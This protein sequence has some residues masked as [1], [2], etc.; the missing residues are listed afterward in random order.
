MVKSADIVII[1]G[2]ISGVSIGY[3]LLKHGAK[4]VVI[5]EKNYLAAG[6]TGR[7]GA[8][9]RQQWGSPLNCIMSKF[10]CEFFES[11]A[12]EL[13][14][15]G[16]IEFHQ[17]G[18]M[19]LVSTEKEL[20]QT[21][22]NIA[23]QN[24]LGINTKLLTP[25]EAKDMAPLLDTNGILAAAFHGRDGHLNPF[26]TTRAFSHAFTRLGGKIYTSTG[27][28][29]IRVENGRITGVDT[30]RGHIA[31]N[32]VVN[33][34][35][36]YV[37]TIA[38]MIDVKLPLYSQRHNILVTE[39]VERVLDP[40][41]MSFSLNFYCQQTPHGSFIMGRTC[42][43]QP[44]DLRITA[45][46]RFPV[47]M[48]KTITKVLPRLK[49]LRMLRQWAGLYNMSPDS[50]PIYDRVPGVDGFY[51]AAGYSGHGFM[52]A[53]FT[54][55]AMTEIVLGLEPTLPWNKLGFSRFND[56]ELILE[57]SVV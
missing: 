34:A 39:P 52:L 24:S 2:G 55:M 56:G 44:R 22:E 26:T 14:Y 5:L 18:Y 51:L 20:A 4:N 41:L 40:M 43:D 54:G 35:G 19:M 36:G 29:G 17:G 21:K 12:H 31:T 1:G 7:C 46:S 32:T 15:D 16:D 13:E 3:F 37:Q 25:S 38:D 8:G 6:A 47:A 48:A 11:A 49:N 42:P 28:T 27:I 33:A 23:L 45:D 9:I 53:P 10:S 30:N 50:H 57:P